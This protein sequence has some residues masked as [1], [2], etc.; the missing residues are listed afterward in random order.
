MAGALIL[1]NS[2]GQTARA[3]QTALFQLP[4]ALPFL[5]V[6]TILLYPLPIPTKHMNQAAPKVIESCQR[7]K[8]YIQIESR[9]SCRVY[10]TQKPQVRTW[11]RSESSLAYPCWLQSQVI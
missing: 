10:G 3:I 6:F 11:P 9:G 2:S 8:V 1:Q 5:L 4:S 7:D